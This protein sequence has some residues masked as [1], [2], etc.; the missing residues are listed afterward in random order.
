MST[1]GAGNMGTLIVYVELNSNEHIEAVPSELTYFSRV[2][3]R[4]VNISE[5]KGVVIPGPD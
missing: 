4:C 5:R 3:D 2:M 1:E